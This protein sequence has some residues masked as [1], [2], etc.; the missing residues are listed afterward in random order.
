MENVFLK[1]MD[2]HAEQKDNKIIDIH[3]GPVI[4]I[5]RDYGCPGRRIGKYLTEIINQK[6]KREHKKEEWRLISKE[7][8][9]ESAKDL[10]LSSQHINDLQKYK[11]RSFFDHITE[12]FSSEYYLSDTKIN[13]TIANFIHTAGTQGNVVIVGRAAE[14]ITKNFKKSFHVKLIAPLNWRIDIISNS[15]N[16]SKS[17]ARKEIIEMDKRRNKF[18][19][20]F[21]GDKPDEE[22][23]DAWFNCK[24]MT[25]DEI[26]ELIIIIAETRGMI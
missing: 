13:N 9:E 8:L 11:N 2:E 19:H 12:F 17:E 20:Y 4:T 16:I 24:E 26:V 3:E 21:E 15:L 23:Y 1:Y 7:I 6:L 18:R 22:F 10:K 5:S 14:A 25:D